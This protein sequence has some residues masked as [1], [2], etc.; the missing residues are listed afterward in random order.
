MPLYIEILDRDHF[1]SAA[2]L[3]DRPDAR[4]L[5]VWESAT[6]GETVRLVDTPDGNSSPRGTRHSTRILFD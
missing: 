6:T 1:P 4:I 5:G 3:A 2:P